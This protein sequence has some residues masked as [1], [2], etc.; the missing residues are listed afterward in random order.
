MWC[1]RE[2]RHGEAEG[3]LCSPNA[4]ILPARP[5]APRRTVYDEESPR[6]GKDAPWRVEGWVG[7]TS[8][9]V[10]DPFRFVVPYRGLRRIGC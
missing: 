8:R 1:W 7:E 5:G 6:L 2:E 4:I 3:S 9:A 10:R